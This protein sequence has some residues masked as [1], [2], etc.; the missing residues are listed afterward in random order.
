MRSQEELI[1]PIL[2]RLALSNN[3]LNIREIATVLNKHP[4]TIRRYIERNELMAVRNGKSF[5]STKKWV[6]EF[7]EQYSDKV[8]STGYY[9][10]THYERLMED[11]LEYCQ[12]PRTYRQLLRFTK[13]KTK[14][15]LQK[16]IT[17]PLMKAGRLRLLYPETPHVNDQKYITV[18]RP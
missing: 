12:K 13:L 3:T 2:E 10:D 18:T 15:Y 5:M 7:L 9:Y 4:E 6:L 14:S 8:V 1:A 17:R 16:T 11:V